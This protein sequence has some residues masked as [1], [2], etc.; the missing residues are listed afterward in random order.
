FS[1]DG[2]IL[3]QQAKIIR[4]TSNAGGPLIKL[5]N[6]HCNEYGRAFSVESSF[7]HHYIVITGAHD[8]FQESF[9]ETQNVHKKQRYNCLVHFGWPHV[10]KVQHVKEP[11]VARNN[12]P[13][14][15][16]ERGN[17]IAGK[18]SLAAS[19]SLPLHM[20]TESHTVKVTPP[21]CHIAKL[22]PKILH[23]RA[24]HRGD[25]SFNDTKKHSERIMFGP[26]TVAVPNTLKK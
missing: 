21:D 8:A 18:S 17:G 12:L 9:W 11:N 19:L 1:P 25:Q 5:I 3:D 2:A 10:Q 22:I 24:C 7:L 6:F 20:A 16:P 23:D 26:E 13:A 15:S 4:W 14:K